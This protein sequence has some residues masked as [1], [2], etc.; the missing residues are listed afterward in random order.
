MNYNNNKPQEKITYD[1][2]VCVFARETLQ[3]SINLDKIKIDHKVFQKTEYEK[4]LLK[5]MK[6]QYKLNQKRLGLC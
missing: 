5:K 6:F 3:H 2:P 1:H 4:A